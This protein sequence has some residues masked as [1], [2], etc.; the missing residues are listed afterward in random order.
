VSL[1][2]EADALRRIGEAASAA[3][4]A[5][6]AAATAEDVQHYESLQL[7]VAASETAAAAASRTRFSRKQQSG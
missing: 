6:D 2:A 7:K 3:A 4:T 5:A 1:K